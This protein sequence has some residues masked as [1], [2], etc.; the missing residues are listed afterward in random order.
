V[1]AAGIAP[2]NRSPQVVSL[3]AGVGGCTDAALSELVAAWH[4]L[5]PHVRAA[6]LS[7]ATDGLKDG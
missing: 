6:I 3:Q 5:A 7:L 4:Q 1:E 2:A